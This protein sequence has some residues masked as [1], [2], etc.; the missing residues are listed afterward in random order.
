MG[1][2]ATRDHYPSQITYYLLVE[3]GLDTKEKVIE[4]REALR[5]ENDSG[6][7][8]KKRRQEVSNVTLAHRRMETSWIFRLLDIGFASHHLSN[9]SID[10]SLS[11]VQHQCKQSTLSD[12]RDN[13][14]KKG[15]IHTVVTSTMNT[16]RVRVL[17]GLGSIG[18][19]L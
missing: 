4:K 11:T 6:N 3:M 19:L 14:Y 18:M 7:S 1:Y 15:V 10:M 5:R 2:D 8:R 16:R 12:T 13:V 17:R 9:T